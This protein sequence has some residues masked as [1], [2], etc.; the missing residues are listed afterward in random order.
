MIKS[1]AVIANILAIGTV[2][3]LLMQNGAPDGA[4]EVF[5]VGI[6]SIAP[7][8]SITQICRQSVAGRSDDRL[9]DL[10]IAA[11]K[12]RLRKQI[13]DSQSPSNRN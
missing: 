2:L 11:Q 7:V 10:F 1:L 9:L 8:L 6:F 4:D 3:Y 12:A 13:A 5:F